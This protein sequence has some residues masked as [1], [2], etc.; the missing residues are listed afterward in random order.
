MEDVSMTTRI[1]SKPLP[2]LTGYG[3]HLSTLLQLMRQ[4]SQLDTFQRLLLITCAQLW[5]SDSIL[6]AKVPLHDMFFILDANDDGR[7]DAQEFV[8]ALRSMT[9]FSGGPSEAYLRGLVRGLDADG[10]TAIEWT[11]YVAV[12]LLSDPRIRMDVDLLRSAFRVLDQH[13]ADG[14]ISV[15]DM[16]SALDGGGADQSLVRI[17]LSRWSSDPKGLRSDDD[18]L[19]LSLTF[20]D[21]QRAFNAAFDT[22]S[23]TDEASSVASIDYNHRR[24]IQCWPD[25][26]SPEH[27]DIG[28]VLVNQLHISDQPVQL[29]HLACDDAHL[30]EQCTK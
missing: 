17:A 29:N 14:K 24:C 19:S 6:K 23:G 1:S 16:L 4:F 25:N 28:R 30:A 26:D 7:I 8:A 3:A 27:K 9:G 12:A 18:E 20:T 5:P 21:V 2:R 10:S 22:P 15:D 13:S 11:E